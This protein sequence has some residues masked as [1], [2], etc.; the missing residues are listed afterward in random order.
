MGFGFLVAPIERTTPLVSCLVLGLVL[1]SVLATLW[2]RRRGARVRHRRD[3]LQAK[4][5]LSI[6]ESHDTLLQEI[7]GLVLR[8]EAIARHM[9]ADDPLRIMMD[10]VLE[11]AD[12]VVL[13]GRERIRNMQVVADSELELSRALAMFAEDFSSDGATSFRLVA[14]GVERK[15]ESNARDGIYWIAKEAIRNAF[16][17][18][19]ASHIEVELNH[20][21]EWLRLRIRDD[22]VGIDSRIV[23]D[24]GSPDH[25]GLAVMRERTLQI[26][27]ELAIW[28][29]DGLGTEV[30]LQLRAAIAYETGRKSSHRK[31]L[32]LIGEGR[33]K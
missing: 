5:E 29:R 26:G 13:D 9:H 14:E 32:R 33:Y 8:F 7:Q 18:A 23:E 21:D 1:L 12:Q 2:L 6:R 31:L 28:G 16:R 15:L 3:E 30:E 22:G 17:H 27:A 19:K 24:E 11:R 20:G 10:T 25:R 4:C